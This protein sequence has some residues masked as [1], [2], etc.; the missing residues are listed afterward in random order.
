[1]LLIFSLN[2]CCHIEL[3]MPRKNAVTSITSEAEVKLKT[4]DEHTVKCLKHV[5]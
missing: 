2:T 1:M 3:L 5:S 4:E